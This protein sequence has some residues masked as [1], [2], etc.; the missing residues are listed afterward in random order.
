MTRGPTA[1]WDEPYDRALLA[2]SAAMLVALAAVEVGRER[3]DRPT[4]IQ[5]R[6]FSESRAFTAG[7]VTALLSY[8]A[9]SGTS[10]L[11][12]N[13]L[14]VV[15]G[16]RPDEAGVVL[17]STPIT[18]MTLSP[19]AGWLSDRFGARSLASAG[20]ACVTGGLLLLGLMPPD[21][22]P[23]ELVPRLAL[24]GVGFG[25]FSSPNT[26]AVMGSVGQGE[27]GLASGVLGTARQVGLGLGL[28]GIGA[29][30]AAGLTPAV[31]Q[32]IFTHSAAL[33]P[34]AIATFAAG[35]RRAFLVAG[36]LAAIGIVT[37]LVRGG[38]RDA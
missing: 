25:L 10:F 30:A 2:A 23:L 4:L 31:Q 24:I 7:I 13:Y 29:V 34:G 35:I 15:L 5:P 38:R 6:L 22:G 32:A 1:G 27:L 26:S 12:A 17:L 36:G 14:Q 8:L 3:A 28:A 19:L 33:D 37:S 21:A 18:Q 20:M 9:T 16:L 11:A